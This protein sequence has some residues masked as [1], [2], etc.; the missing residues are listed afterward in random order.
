M[1]LR[2]V[3]IEAGDLVAHQPAGLPQ[4]ARQRHLQP[5]RVV[6]DGLGGRAAPEGRVAR[7]AQ[8]GD[9]RAALRLHGHGRR[10]RGRVERQQ[11]AV[12]RVERRELGLQGAGGGR[13]GDGFGGRVEVQGEER[14]GL[15]VVHCGMGTGAV[16]ELRGCEPSMVVRGD[17]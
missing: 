15:G 1:R 7:L 8:L 5:Q 10:R 6:L 4:R 11:R 16:R 12:Q 13:G 2:A 17:G 14:E 3:G 9:L